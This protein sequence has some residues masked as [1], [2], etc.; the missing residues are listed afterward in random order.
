M[1]P[2]N[3]RNIV[4][5]AAITCG[6]YAKS[7]SQAAPDS[8][9]IERY[10]LDFVVPDMPAFKA[11]GTDPS[12]ILRPSD[13]KKFAAMISPFYS[14][15]RGVV[16]KNFAV[17]FAPWKLASRDW[18]L[19]EYNKSGSKR[20]LYRS[21]FSLGTINDSSQFSSKIAL[22]YRVSFLL[23]RADIYR[24][25]EIRSHIFAQQQR[26]GTA[27]VLLTNY[28]VNSIM[29]I[30]PPAAATY[31]Q[32]H[33]AEFNEFLSTIDIR[34]KKTPDTTLQ[35][36]YDSF[37]FSIRTDPNNNQTYTTDE[38]KDIIQTYGKSA[39]AYIEDYKKKN[40]NA[41]RFDIALAWVGQSD[42]TLLSTIEY[43]NF[44]AWITGAF[45]VH[46]GGQLLVGINAGLPRSTHSDSTR[47]QFSGSIR[48]YLGTRDFRGF[49][50][51]QYKYHRFSEN[52]RSLLVN[53][54]AEFRLGN[55]FWVVASTG[56]D[57]YLQTVNPIHRLVSS[58]D[59]RYGFNKPK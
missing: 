11:L 36:L 9:L 1:K 10:L 39:D 18:T 19:S 24:A 50:E 55:S 6:L 30:Q 28:W 33:K 41:T 45:R 57:N 22:G 26:A 17:E 25:A 16:P 34:L 44:A 4:L 13:V 53:L 27:Y 14:G 31:Y 35:Q 12:N 29:R 23:K 3:I 8:T 32:N 47:I 46:N 15:G 40:W 49:L 38:L 59:L 54:G 51:T 37:L 7:Y 2:K 43:G 58:I 42:T 5:L 52:D 20:F 56:L 48:Y 21:S